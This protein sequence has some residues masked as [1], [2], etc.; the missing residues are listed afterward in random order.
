[1]RIKKSNVLIAEFMGIK[2]LNYG[3][4]AIEGREYAYDSVIYPNSLKYH[5]SW[6]WLIPVVHKIE[7]TPVNEEMLLPRFTI[8]SSFVRINQTGDVETCVY[9]K[10][11][12]GK[13]QT[14]YDAIIDFIQ[15]HNNLKQ[16]SDK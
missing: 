7:C 5:S 16:P 9:R 8:D 1:M 3:W 4:I 11:L 6:E 12:E 10:D 15:W 2:N 13:L 14:T